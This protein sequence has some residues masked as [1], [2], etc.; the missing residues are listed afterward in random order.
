MK[1]RQYHIYLADLD[2]SFGSE[3]GKIRPVVVIQTDMLNDVGH[4][5]TVTCPLTT[6]L[7]DEKDA[8]PLRIYLNKK[9]V[10]IKEDSDILVDQIR[11]IDNKRFIKHI[12]KLSPTHKAKLINNLK[13][14]LFE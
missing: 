10:G 8:F 3:P 2:P 11:A 6:K 7:I 12:G 9:T 5:S 4:K 14:I 1:I 13:I